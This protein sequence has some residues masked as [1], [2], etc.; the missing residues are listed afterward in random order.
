MIELIIGLAVAVLLFKFLFTD[1]GDEAPRKYVINPRSEKILNRNLDWLE[2]RWVQARKER[3]AGELESVPYW[4]FDD[5]A[6][7]QIEKIKEIGLNIRGWC[8]T[9]GEAADIISLFEAVDDENI[10]ILKFF[11]VPVKGMNQ[12]QA[13]YK[14]EELL[15]DPVNAQRWENKA[16]SPIQKEFFRYFGIAE[17][18]DLKYV[19][20]TKQINEQLTEMARDEPEKVDEWNNYKKL[21]FDINEPFFLEDHGIKEIAISLYRP[22]VEFLLEEGY[23]FKHLMSNPRLV[24][25]TVIEMKPDIR[26]NAG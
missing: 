17:P 1:S 19:E 22:A 14:V 25:D 3:D 23:T 11:H 5:I 26:R 2:E 24:A 6:D 20:A 12:A 8:P 21:Y 18:L 9:K 13:R 15:A 7:Q 16:A 10:E 4:F